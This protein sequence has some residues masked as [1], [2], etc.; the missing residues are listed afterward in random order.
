M[1]AATLS[2]ES[3]GRLIGLLCPTSENS[4]VSTLPCCYIHTFAFI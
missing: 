1:C 4:K 2:T 3:W